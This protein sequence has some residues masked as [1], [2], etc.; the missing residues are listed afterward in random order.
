VIVPEKLYV[1]AKSFTVVEGK[2]VILS[3]MNFLVVTPYY[4]GKVSDYRIVEKPRH[5]TILDSTKNTQV[6]K[7]SQ[8]HLNAGV[9]LYKHNGDEFLSDSFRMVVT[10]SDKMSEPFDVSIIVQPV[11]DEIPV[12]VNRTKLNVWQGGSLILT[13]TNLAAIDNDT[14]PYDI[15]FNV[16]GVRNGYIS[17][18]TSPDVDIYNFTQSQINESQVVFTHTSKYLQYLEIFI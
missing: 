2:D 11:N 13:S 16:T 14:S 12:L 17:L 5:G 15:I 7:F 9:I 8:K 10:A 4:A 6:K 18:I 1:E 3:E